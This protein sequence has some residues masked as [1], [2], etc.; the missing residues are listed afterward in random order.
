MADQREADREGAGEGR[1]RQ[2]TLRDVAEAAGVHVSTVSRVLTPE[3]RGLVN[4]ETAA[5][6][7]ALVQQLGYSPNRLAQGLKTRRS[8]TVGVLVNDITNP[9]FPFVVRGIEDQLLRSGYTA[10]VTNTDASVDRER[11]AFE[12]LRARQVDGF[13]MTTAL[14]VDPLVEEACDQG[15]PLVLVVRNVDDHRAAAVTSDERLGTRIA[16][17]HLFDLGHRR[18]ACISGPQTVSTGAARLAGFTEAMAARG[19]DVD[20][21]LVAEAASFTIDEGE[22]AMDELLDSG[23]PFTGVLAGNDMLAIGCI[24]TLTGRGLRCP[25]DI[26]VIGFNDMPLADRLSPP[27]TTLRV[28]YY[29]LGTYAADLFIEQLEGRPKR[30]IT[31]VQDLVVRS[32][33]G[34]PPD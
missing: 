10:L 26:S 29:D 23:L 14:R 28:P 16:V 17:E 32:S 27:L 18:I 31:V 30:E 4:D 19:L 3:T 12:A 2:V 24:S 13:I 1:P 34:P 9:V 21:A 7:E 15:I 5:R 22:R 20:P 8:K 6:I 25:Q 33:T 11:T